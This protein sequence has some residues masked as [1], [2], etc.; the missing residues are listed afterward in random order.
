MKLKST[1]MKNVITSRL[2]KLLFLPLFILIAFTSCQNE[3]TDVT[4]PNEQEILV[5]NSPLANLVT[6]TT[7]RDGSFD[8]ILDSANCISVNLPVTI[9]VNGLEITIDSEEDLAIIEA[10]FDEFA[11]DLDEIQIIFPI[12]IT[13]N[14]YTTYTINNYDELEAF[15]E[16]CEGENEDDDDI[17][18]ID[19][20]YPITISIFN[21]NFD[22]IDTITINSD[23][24][25]HDFIENL[26]GGLLASINFPVT[27]ILADGSTI[28]VENNDELQAAIEAAEDACDEDDDNDWDDDDNNDIDPDALNILCSNCTWTVDKLEIGDQ[29]LEGQYEGWVFTFVPDGPV[30]VEDPNGTIHEGTWS[31]TVTDTGIPALNLQIN[32]LPDFNNELWILNEIDD[33]NGEIKVDFRNGIDRLRFEQHECPDDED[34]CTEEE[35]DLYLTDCIW[36]V[37]NFNDSNDFVNWD[38]QFNN[39]G[40]F[41]ITNPNETITAMW[42]TS[43]STNGVI[44]EF[45]GI[46]G[47]SDLQGMNGEWTVIE[48]RDD[49]LKIVNGDQFIVI[50]S[51]CANA[52]DCNEEN[53]SA[54][55][56][57]C[58]W[59]AGFNGSNNFGDYEFY[60]NANQELL[61]QHSVN[62]QEVAGTWALSSDP[63]TGVVMTINLADP[64]GDFNGEWTVIECD[65]ERIK[66]VNG[67]LYIVFERECEDVACTEAEVDA[68]LLECIWNVVSYNGDDHLIAFDLNFDDGQVFTITTAN[69]DTITAGWSTSESTNG[70]LVEFSNVAGSD[71]QAINGTWLVVECNEGRLKLQN[72]NNTFMV[73]ERDCN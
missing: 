61:V 30:L 68:F 31:I 38:L 42:S 71:I 16:E 41:T 1:I 24:E 14:D 55:L 12:V 28:V 50:E 45:S 15:I 19:F 8:N 48:C 22:V 7:L 13:L 47:T 64:L 67:D 21:S 69:G 4:G 33:E 72:D 17:E 56:M 35:V 65:E 37:V 60:F 43:G 11:D 10:I 29:N 63:A 70:V 52:P 36:N 26:E 62:D 58:F 18:C 46:A 40:T 66:L 34:D 51:D 39:D 49:R 53:V 23:E 54:Y 5:A 2:S 9:V 3:V 32:D 27:M 73:I 20:Q 57:E 25:L 59:R 44:L 6:A